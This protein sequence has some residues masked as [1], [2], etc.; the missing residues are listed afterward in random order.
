MLV[1]R[2]HLLVVNESRIMCANKRNI[3]EA[4]MS[5]AKPPPFL[6][7]IVPRMI[8]CTARHSR[9]ISVEQV[10]QQQK[11]AKQIQ[12]PTFLVSLTMFDVLCCYRCGLGGAA[13]K[14]L[15]P[16]IVGQSRQRHGQFR[17]Y[18]AFRVFD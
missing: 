14:Q 18:E 16:F 3:L 2:E 15:H 12:R 17:S 5:N 9:Y 4:H 10:H 13:V 7:E 1:R 11:K 8:D 6:E